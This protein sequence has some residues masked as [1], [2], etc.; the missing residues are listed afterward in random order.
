MEVSS[1]TDLVAYLRD[2]KVFSVKGSASLVWA[3]LGVLRG[4]DRPQYSG[5]EIYCCHSYL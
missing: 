4:A 2:K 1:I 3:S 5:R